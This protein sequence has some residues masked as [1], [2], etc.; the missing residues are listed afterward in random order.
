[1]HARVNSNRYGLKD[2]FFNGVDDFVNKAMNQPQVLN[3]GRI[4]CRVKCVCILLKT[5]SEI[6]HHLYTDVFLP[7]YYTW[8]DHGEENQID[9]HSSSGENAGG[10]NLSDAIRPFVNVPNVNANM[11]NETV[12]EGEVPNE[13]AQRFY[14][15]LI[16]GNQSIHV[17]ASESRLSISIKLLA[18]MSNWHVHQKAMDFF[19]QILIDVCPTK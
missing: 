17:G 8:F 9:G 2:G 12:S 5:P 15:G 1:M 14:D 6:R 19:I 4:R 7:N 10:D 13:E 3:K 16:S 11:E 18:S